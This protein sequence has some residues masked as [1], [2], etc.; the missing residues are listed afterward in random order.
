MMVLI[1]VQMSLEVHVVPGC[2]LYV[3]V[4]V[5]VAVGMPLSSPYHV[6]AY[7]S[8]D[9]KDVHWFQHKLAPRSAVNDMLREADALA[10]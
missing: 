5:S 4:C 7:T 2:G 9:H 8:A 6:E 3:V 10:G 1:S